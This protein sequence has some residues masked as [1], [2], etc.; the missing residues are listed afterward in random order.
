MK[1]FC[2]ALSF[3][4][5]TLIISA[6]KP[7]P[8]PIEYDIDECSSCRMTISDV[9]FGAELVTQKGRVYKFDDIHCLKAFIQDENVPAKNIS[10]LWTIDFSS[11][12][13]FIS[14]ETAYLLENKDL[15]SPMGS[16]IASFAVEDSAISYQSKYSGK[17]LKWSEY[18][19]E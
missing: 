8:R 19:Q 1:L 17:I 7:Q 15:K 3:L 18:L 12:G 13:D 5:F 6:C 11:P 9:R 2:K 16:D 10:S 14:L 4:S